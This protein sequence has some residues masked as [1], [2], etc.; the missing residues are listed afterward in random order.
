MR[1]TVCGGMLTLSSI[2]SVL[3]YLSRLTSMMAAL[4]TEGT[5]SLQVA[6][7][8]LF[9]NVFGIIIWYPIPVMRNVPIHAARQLGK[10]CRAWRGFPILYIVIMFLVMPL[11]LLA[12]SSLFGSG[13]KSLV[14]L[15]GCLIGIFFIFIIWFIWWWNWK[16]GRWIVGQFFH[17]RQ[18]K[19]FAMDTLPYDLKYLQRKIK[20]LQEH[21]QCEPAATP[22]LSPDKDPR[23]ALITVAD[24]M[25]LSTR[26]VEALIAHTG[27]PEDEDILGP[28]GEDLGRFV[29]LEKEPMPPVDMTGW[30]TYQMIVLVVILACVA[31]IF[32]WVG[33]LMARPQTSAV[34]LGAFLAIM[35]GLFVVYR[36]LSFFVFGGKQKSIQAYETRQLNKTATAFYLPTMAQ[37]TA[38]INKLAAHTKLPALDTNLAAGYN[39]VVG[40]VVSAEG[41]TGK[42]AAEAPAEAPVGDKAK[43]VEDDAE[44]AEV[45]A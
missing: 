23:S 24:D 9:F 22:T 32:V 6:L 5:D 27:L 33:H 26:M 20:E 38:D 2:I 42:T 44:D 30:I 28:N 12:I 17:K 43:D 29:H 34:A 4:V 11:A 35:V 31:G 36:V 25:E 3:H 15:G 40:S 7:A 18:R 13:E 21:T 45:D 41:E 39:S 10:A 16:Q 14:I 8:H 37:M 1:P 19:V